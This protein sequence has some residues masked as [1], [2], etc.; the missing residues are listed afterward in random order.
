MHL[1]VYARVHIYT[2]TGIST[3]TVAFEHTSACGGVFDRCD[4]ADADAVALGHPPLSV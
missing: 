2:Y 4:H 3:H 1:H